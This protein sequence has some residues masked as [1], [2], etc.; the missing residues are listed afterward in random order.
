MQ[1]HENQNQANKKIQR[2]TTNSRTIT[3]WEKCITFLPCNHCL[4]YLVGHELFQNMRYSITSRGENTGGG[5]GQNL[6]RYIITCE[7]TGPRHNA[8]KM[9]EFNEIKGCFFNLEKEIPEACPS[10]EAY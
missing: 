10:E 8:T 7:V 2:T 3:G 5:R 9:L 6:C 4:Y 1:Q